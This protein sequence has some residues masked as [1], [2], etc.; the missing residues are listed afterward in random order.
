MSKLNQRAADDPVLTSLATEKRPTS[1]I[2]FH[3]LHRVV[4][5]YLEDR[6]GYFQK[7]AAGLPAPRLVRLEFPVEPCEPLVWLSGQGAMPRAYWRD[8]QQRVEIAGAGHCLSVSSTEPADLNALFSQFR[9]WLA[10]ADP[11]L[12]FLGGLAFDLSR[13]SQDL[14]QPFGSYHFWVPQLECGRRDN[15]GYFAVNL[16]LDPGLSS[17]SPVRV[18]LRLLSSTNGKESLLPAALPG[19]QQ[20]EDLPDLPGWGRAIQNVLDTIEHG[21]LEKLVLARQSRFVFQKEPDS[22]SLFHRLAR[23]NPDAYQFYFQLEGGS[24]FLGCSPERLF[25][26]SGRLLFTEAVAGTRPRGHTAREDRELAR[27][28]LQSRKDRHEHFL[29][30][31]CILQGLEHLCEKVESQ[32]EPSVLKLARVQHLASRFEGLLKPGVSDADIL[33]T[34]HPTPA[35]GGYPT[36]AA[37]ATLRRLEPFHRGWYAG[38][39]G[40]LGREEAEFAVGI[41]SG[42]FH[43][44]EGYL[45]TGAGIVSGSSVQAEWNEI[46]NKLANFLRIFEGEGDC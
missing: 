30:V 43:Q 31:K 21:N 27:Q 23:A 3:Q 41:R 40:W 33:A 42:L 12:K 38:P 34:L 5:R 24:A 46:E 10:T 37:L 26:R 11:G 25:R 9:R 36:R 32:N 6:E 19:I 29:V 8:R 16:F 14:W 2:P 7:L 45:Y 4:G 20:R 35:V 13:P 39:V 22:L 28:L 1:P 15:Q 17:R 44:Q 18:A